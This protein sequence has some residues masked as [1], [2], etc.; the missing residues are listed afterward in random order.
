MLTG[1][2]GS[3]PCRYLTLT[4]HLQKKYKLEPA[5]SH[6]VW[7]LDDYVFLPYLFGSGQLLGKSF[8]V[9]IVVSVCTRADSLMLWDGFV[10]VPGMTPK[11]ALV[12][13]KG[14]DDLDDLWTISLRRVFEFKRGPFHEHSV[15]AASQL[16]SLYPGAAYS[17]GCLS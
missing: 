11:E 14:K 10:G 6:G 15:S 8:L 1:R 3:L 7:G 12:L 4:N 2:G 17:L 13:A 9:I 16:L 5:G